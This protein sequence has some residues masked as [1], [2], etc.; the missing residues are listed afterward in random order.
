MN[1]IDELELLSNV[2]AVR[3]E[4]KALLAETMVAGHSVRLRRIMVILGYMRE[5]LEMLTAFHG[6]DERINEAR[7][8]TGSSIHSVR[9]ADSP[10]AVESLSRTKASGP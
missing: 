2:F 6:R 4:A 8:A 1:P 5:H 7:G 3:R 9:L 10:S